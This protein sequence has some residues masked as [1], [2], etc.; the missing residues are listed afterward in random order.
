MERFSKGFYRVKKESF[1]VVTSR[2][3]LKI[4]I[5]Q[6]LADEINYAFRYKHFPGVY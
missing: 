1:V 3:D 2:R 4:F 6:L 5:R